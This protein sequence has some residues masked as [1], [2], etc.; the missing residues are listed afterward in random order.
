MLRNGNLVEIYRKKKSSTGKIPQ[1][2]SIANNIPQSN[3]NVN[4]DISS[5]KYSIKNNENNTQELG[6]STFR[7][8][9]NWHVHFSILICS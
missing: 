2:T 3:N 4:S 7:L 5:T 9:T 6:N 1:S 8:L